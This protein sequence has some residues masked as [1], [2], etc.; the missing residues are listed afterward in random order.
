MLADGTLVTPEARG[1]LPGVTRQG[2]ITLCQT[3]NIP[4]HI[5]PL[6]HKAL[7]L[8]SEVILLSA[9]LGA[10]AVHSLDGRVLNSQWAPRLQTLL[11]ACNTRS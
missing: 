11:D 6:H 2:M 5:G 9:V 3:H 7:V 10:K 4:I 8:C 1:I